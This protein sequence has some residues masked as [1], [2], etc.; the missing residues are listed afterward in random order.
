MG[1]ENEAKIET[2][3][4]FDLYGTD[5]MAISSIRRLPSAIL[6]SSNCDFI[7]RRGLHKIVSRISCGTRLLSVRALQI[8]LPLQGRHV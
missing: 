6:N 5:K 3:Y 1:K 4:R 2:V 8:P 7:G